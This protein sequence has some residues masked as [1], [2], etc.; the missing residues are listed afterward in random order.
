MQDSIFYI[1]ICIQTANGPK[2]FGRFE[3]GRDRVA[4]RE[5]FKKLKGS[6]A[7]NPRDMLYIEFMETVNALPVN[8]AILTCDLQELGSNVMMITQEVFRITNLKSSGG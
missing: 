4:A 2:S 3:F 5:L 1:N 6:P 8:I 7:A